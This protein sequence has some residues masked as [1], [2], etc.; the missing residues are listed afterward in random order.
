MKKGFTLIEIMISITILATIFSMV[1]VVL[2]STLNTRDLIQEQS[3]AD[4]LGARLIN[5]ITRDIQNAY[6]YKI[7]GSSFVGNSGYHGD[8]LNFITNTDSLLGEV[9]Q[10][11][12]ITEVGYYLKENKQED[13]TYFLLRREDR[14]VDDKP[15]EGGVSV[16]LHNRITEFEL[17][18]IDAEGKIQKNW[19]NQKNKALP[20]AVT[21]KISIRTAPANAPKDI[22]EHAI[23]T[24]K[25]CIPILVSTVQPTEDKKK[26]KESENGNSTK[27]KL[28]DE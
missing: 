4:R 5:V 26:E 1:Q 14:F 24:V 16:K 27:K 21:V 28:L 19:D 10:R 13:N 20:K 22:R 23:H 2:I 11:S 25:A 17:R 15:L 3:Y 12:D 7:E 18:Y 9:S 6:I 8:K